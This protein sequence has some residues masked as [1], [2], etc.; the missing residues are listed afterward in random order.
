MQSLSE[1]PT[2]TRPKLV[3]RFLGFA[4]FYRWCIRNCST[5]ATP[6]HALTSSKIKFQWSPRADLAF[7]R[8]RESFTLAPVLTLPDSRQQLIV[9]VDAS[10]AGIGAVVSQSEAD[11]KRH[12]CAFLC[13]ADCV[14]PRRITMWGTGTTVG[15]QGGPGGATGWGERSS[16]SWFELTIKTWPA[17]RQACQVGPFFNRLN[18]VDSSYTVVLIPG[19]SSLAQHQGLP[20]HLASCVVGAVTWAMRKWSWRESLGTAQHVAAC[21]VELDR[22]SHVQ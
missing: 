2:P 17:Q 16:L 8:L 22:R 21:P 5:V 18:F 12:P 15:R 14:L 1:W 7:R 13:P 3:E 10:D 19:T 11:N 20:Q 9:E 4:N 6:L